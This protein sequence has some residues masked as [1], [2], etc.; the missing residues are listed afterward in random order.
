MNRQRTTQKSYW[1]W[2]LV[3]LRHAQMCHGIE[4][5]ATDHGLACLSF[6]QARGKLAA[7]D[8][9]NAEHRSFRQ[10]AAMIAGIIFPS[11][12]PCLRM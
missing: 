8:R 11:G 1:S 2:D 9:F 6:D 4:R 3:T 7:E 5:G 12:R 10:G